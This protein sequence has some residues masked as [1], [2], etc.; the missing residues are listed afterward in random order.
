MLRKRTKGPR[1]KQTAVERVY[2]FV[3]RSIMGLSL[4]PG[5]D[6]SDTDIAARIGIS[7]TPVREALRQLE[8]EGLV[9]HT[10]HR[11]W[12]V[13][14]LQIRDVE[15]LFEIKECLECMLVRQ[16]TKRLTPQDKSLLVKLM[17]SLEEATQKKDQQAWL[18]ADDCLEKTLYSAASNARAKQIVSSLNSQW[19]WIW[20][21]IIALGDRMD[22]SARE[23]RAI[24]DR[25]FAGDADG[26]AALALEHLLSVKRLL[27]SLLT[28]FVIPLTE[29]AGRGNATPLQA[30]RGKGRIGD[31][32]PLAKSS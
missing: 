14:A 9:L 4:K 24:L 22:Q 11:G 27:L 2:D 21:G 18:A 20:V 16:A 3:K 17:A 25:V 12:M 6:I 7:R 1:P 19:H 26:A 5:E 28:N 23:H 30:R 8:L 31:H 32:P 15:N 13:N 29:T 10:P